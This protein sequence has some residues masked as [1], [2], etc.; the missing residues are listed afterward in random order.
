MNA[1]ERI[2]TVLAVWIVVNA[3]T[4]C[5]KVAPSSTKATSRCVSASVHRRAV[6]SP[7]SR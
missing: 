7:R 3:A 5:R 6:M 2:V 4:I 1:I